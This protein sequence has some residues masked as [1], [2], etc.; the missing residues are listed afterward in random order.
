MGNHKSKEKKQRCGDCDDCT[1]KKVDKGEKHAIDKQAYGNIQPWSGFKLTDTNM[2]TIDKH[3]IY[4]SLP[5]GDQSNL[6][7]IT[8]T[9]ENGRKVEYYGQIGCHELPE[10][11]GQ[12]YYPDEGEFWV[13]NFANGHPEGQAQVYLPSGHYFI[14]SCKDS[15]LK[16]GR[17]HHPHGEIYEGE[18]VS[19]SGRILRHGHGTIYHKNG[20]RTKGKFNSDLL[21][22]GAVIYNKDGFTETFSQKSDK[23][24]D[25]NN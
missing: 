12:L 8:A 13:A 4:I 17:L 3:P 7:H 23:D 16:E 1:G 15:F 22:P 14:G 20:C 6:R 11:I 18:V 24:F 5:A 9:L 2:S 25:L 19:Q 21:E 10:G